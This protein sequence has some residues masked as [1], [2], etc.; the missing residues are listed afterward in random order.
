MKNKPT[1]QTQPNSAPP[2]DMQTEAKPIEVVIKGG[3]N[4]TL[5]PS[6]RR[7]YVR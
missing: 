6:G 1:T 3:Q 2:A 4:Y 7:K 5:T